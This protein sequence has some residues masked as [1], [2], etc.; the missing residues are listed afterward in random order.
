MLGITF[1]GVHSDI[2]GIV[3]RSVDRT[4][5]PNLSRRQAYIPNKH[6]SYDFNGNTYQ[7]RSISMVMSYIGSTI[8]NMR[9]VNRDIA[10]WLS[11]DS[12][13]ELIFDDEPGVYYLARLFDSVNIDSRKRRSKSNVVFECLPFAFSISEGSESKE[14]TGADSIT[15]TYGGTIE[16]G[17][18][19]PQESLFSISAD[20]TFTTLTLVLNGITLNYTAAISSEELIIDNINATAE[21]DGV[22][23]LTEVTGDTGLFLRLIEGAN[24]LAITGSDLNCTVT[25][26]YREQYL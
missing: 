22:N 24:V 6:G 16:L 15:I 5:L 19:S 9:S 2:H 23:K 7:N 3:V 11:S 20:G 14:V 4:M 26:T 8:V 21:V 18:G 10:N 17:L 13:K 25:V 1:G 12:Y